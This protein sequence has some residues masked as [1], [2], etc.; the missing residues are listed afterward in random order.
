MRKKIIIGS[1]LAVFLLLS[2]PNISAINNTIEKLQK[3]EE[4]G[5]PPLPHKTRIIGFISDMYTDDNHLYVESICTLTYT[6]MEYEYF[7]YFIPIYMK[8]RV[9]TKEIFMD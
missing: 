5:I 6:K 4:T 8:P 1:L 7:G 9:I 2:I 3:S